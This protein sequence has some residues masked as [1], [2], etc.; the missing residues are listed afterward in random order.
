MKFIKCEAIS[1]Q[2]FENKVSKHTDC[3]SIIINS[4]HIID[5]YKYGNYEKLSHD[6]AENFSQK[7][8][9]PVSELCILKITLI[10]KRSWYI[11]VPE[12]NFK[13]FK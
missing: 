4:A 2:N 9:V 3:N 12:K 7:F 1:Y 11:V 6:T 5:I 8:D 13:E 10:D